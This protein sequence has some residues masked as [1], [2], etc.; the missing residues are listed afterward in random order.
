M[1][2]HPLPADAADLIICLRHRLG[3]R[4][5]RGPAFGGH[6]PLARRLPGGSPALP[7]MLLLQRLQTCTTT[8]LSECIPV[9][10]S[11]VRL[12]FS[13]PYNT[14]RPLSGFPMSP[15]CCCCIIPSSTYNLQS[16]SGGQHALTSSA[17]SHLCI[18]GSTRGFPLTHSSMQHPK[19]KPPLMTAGDVLRHICMSAST[20]HLFHMQA[21]QSHTWSQDAPGGSARWR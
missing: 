20:Y 10:T 6:A 1:L 18:Y 15:V 13:A 16:Y 9:D 17:G 5:V 4:V 19:R 2:A 12:L 21:E 11:R 8:L 14:T 3:H 7:R